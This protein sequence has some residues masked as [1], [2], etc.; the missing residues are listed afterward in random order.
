[1]SI[2]AAFNNALTGL[3]AA[4][5]SAQVIS[6]NISNALTPGYAAREAQFVSGPTGGVRLTG[7]SRAVDPAL[8]A[9]NRLVGAEAGMAGTRRQAVERMSEL[10][11]E[12]GTG[13][14]L[15]GRLSQLDAQLIE[16]A[17]DPASINRLTA[18]ANTAGDISD[19]LNRASD[20]VQ[21]V[22]FDADRDIGLQVKALNEGLQRVERLNRDITTAAIR[23][24]DINSL[25]DMRQREIDTIS[26]IVPVRE[27][28]RPNQGVSLITTNGQILFDDRPAKIEFAAGGVAGAGLVINDRPVAVT[29]PQSRMGGGTLSGTFSVRDELAPSMGQQIDG[30]A[31]DLIARMDNVPGLRPAGAPGLFTDE[32]GLFSGADEAGIAGRITLNAA[33]DPRKGGEVWRLR[34]GLGAAGPGA[35]GDGSL[36]KA[37]RAAL[38]ASRTSPSSALGSSALT[39]GGQADSVMS[40]A[41]GQLFRAEAEE[42][43]ATTRS[44]ELTGRMLEKGVDTDAELQNM[45]LVEQMYGANTRVLQAADTMLQRLLE[46]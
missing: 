29:G 33:V 20:G 38:D 15:S 19:F 14:S 28:T 37:T 5:R 45:L 18:V 11:G 42:T 34:D 16:A 3:G 44:T 22:I 26:Q 31:R 30:F 8:L 24:E 21:Q 46:I 36:L 4:S 25:K 12:P 2:S 35:Q 27:L 39:L 43:F 23:G 10:L 1:M 13:N 40:F 41:G 7:V 6:S 9:E 32:G 17:S